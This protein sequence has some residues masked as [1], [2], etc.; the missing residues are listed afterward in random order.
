MVSA[1]CYGVCYVVHAV[2]RSRVG[3]RLP[4]DSRFVPCPGLWT[5]VGVDDMRD[6]DNVEDDEDD[7]S[8]Q[9]VTRVDALCLCVY[10]LCE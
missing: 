3:C 6:D 4:A 10:H 9:W 1:P 5:R 7:A 8:E 2:T